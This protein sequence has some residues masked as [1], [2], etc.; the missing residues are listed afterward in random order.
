MSRPVPVSRLNWYV[1]QKLEGDEKL[2]DLLVSGEISN[3]T[4]HQRSGH[5]YFVLKDASAAVKAVMFRSNAASLSFR[6]E[7]GM[8]VIVRCT[9]S[10]YERDG[11]YQIYVRELIPDGVGALYLAYEQLKSRLE[12][13]GLFDAAHKRPLPRFPRVV[14]VVTSPTGAAIQDLCNILGRRWPMCRVL[15]AP[16]TVQGPGSG[17]SVRQGLLALEAGGECDVIIIGR[18]GG[19]IEDL[20][21]F[22][23]EA[24][25]RAVYACTVPVISAVGHETDFTIA[26]FVADLRAPTPSAAAELAVPDAREILQ[27]LDVTAD[28]L[29]RMVYEKLNETRQRLSVCAQRVEAASPRGRISQMTRAVDA[30]AEDVRRSL[31]HILQTKQQ[32]VQSMARLVDSLS[33]LQILT[34]GYGVLLHDGHALRSVRDIRQGDRF[35]ARLS[36]GEITA[37]AEEITATGREE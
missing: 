6:P 2:H 22:N 28:A 4:M 13:E 8:K 10:L 18:G 37:V 27:Q 5:I 30:C 14:G 32:S 29:S 3:L 12:E 33:P 25:A 11:S 1:K 17:D 21:G 35:T 15:L 16:A 20:W 26:D 24:L 19:S 31:M 23:D 36:D 34:R 9:V 7:N